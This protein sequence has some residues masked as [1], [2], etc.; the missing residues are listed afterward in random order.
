MLFLI[1]TGHLLATANGIA[2]GRLCL[3][4]SHQVV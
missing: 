1:M 2:G 3:L 4:V